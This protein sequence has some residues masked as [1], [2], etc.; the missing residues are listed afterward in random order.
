MKL[1]LAEPGVL[2]ISTPKL[3]EDL[4]QEW[5]ITD[6][7][8]FPAQLNL[9]DEIECPK[10]IL[11]EKKRFHSGVMSALFI[12][13]RSR[14]DILLPIIYLSSKVLEPTK[15]HLKKFLKVL[16]YLYHT[17]D[18]VIRLY[19][20][21]DKR[22]K[23]YVDASYG[24]HMKGHSHTGAVLKYGDATLE[25]KSSK[26][27][28]VTKSS[29]ESEVVAASDETGLL[30][31][32]NEFLR[33]QGYEAEMESPGVLFQDNQSAIKLEVN[34]KSSSNRTKHISI[35]NFWLKDKV[36]Q[37]DIVI[38]YLPTEDMIADLLTKPLQGELFYKF[39]KQIMN[40]V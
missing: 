19:V 20:G 2:C 14:P 12:A 30:I 29:C 35:R 4:L 1:D 11:D 18:L 8:E 23:L 13:K 9:F 40:E 25:V 27:K 26:Q 24:V 16:R 32:V 31:H 36:S 21:N 10:L 6:G 17:K 5:N 15:S 33:I 34:G 7:S 37:G 28:I 39:R 38:E 3:I 22:L